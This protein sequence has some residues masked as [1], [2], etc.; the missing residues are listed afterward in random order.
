MSNGEPVIVFDKQAQII[1]NLAFTEAVKR[2]HG[3]VTPEHLL[4][5]LSFDKR[6]TKIMRACG[7]DIE[8]ARKEMDEFF[9]SDLVPSS[10][11]KK[12]KPT[13]AFERILQ[14]SVNQALS[15]GRDMATGSSLLAS[16]FE[17]TD[18]H[19]RYFLE[20]QNIT[21]FDVIQ[22]ISHGDFDD[23]DDLMDELEEMEGNA[24]QSNQ[25]QSDDGSKRTKVGKQSPLEKYTVNLCDRVRDGKV[26]PII[27]RETE[28][29]RA[30]QV[31]CRRRKNN[32]LFVGEPGVGKTALAEG[33]AQYI[34]EERVPKALLDA[35]IF[36]L[37][38]GSLMAGSKYR[39]DFE[40]R[41]KGILKALKKYAK[42]VLFIDEIHTIVGAG[43]V[44][45]GS[46]DLSNL[47]KPALANG[48]IR[49]MGATTYKEY[50]SQF[51]NDAAL[52]RRFLKIDVNEPSLEDAKNILEGIK[53]AFEEYHD[54]EYDQEALE[55]AVE[56]S[57]RYLSE[58]KLPDKAID[59]IDEAAARK[60]LYAD[61]EN[62]EETKVITVA[63][64]QSTIASMSKVNVED[65]QEE[66][67]AQLNHLAADLKALV[68]GQDHA[69]E[70][71]VNKIK[72]AR[73]GLNDDDKPIGSFLF[74]G[75]TGV[76]KTELAK[77]LA[78]QMKLEFN[79]F[80]MSEYMERHSVARLIGAP[81][82][83]VGYNEG[84]LLTDTI[85]QNPHSLVLLDEIEKAHPDVHNILLQIMDHG[86]V[87]D[88]VG[89]K[90]DCRNIILI[91]TTNTG[92][93]ELSSGKIGF[94]RDSDK[95]DLPAE[96]KEVFS[97]EFRNRL[98]AMIP[99]K[100]L[101]MPQV[102]LVAEKLLK[103]LSN[104]LLKKKITL[105]W[106]KPVIKILAKG[107]YSVEYGARPMR[108]LISEKI[109]VPL[110]QKMID[111]SF[112]DGDTVKLSI[113]KGEISFG[114]EKSE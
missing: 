65:L 27:G 60:A 86:F 48:D 47:L 85:H 76:G 77:R 79:R 81:P 90:T 82:G 51:Q 45:G 75:P 32:P 8:R 3:Y 10:D 25:S 41:L 71:V 94:S 44:S 2:K 54:V 102:E 58:L 113:T 114:A 6:V 40:Q 63:D 62:S 61:S 87:T 14:N 55:Q 20:K 13:M 33:M 39:G 100:P 78:E 9:D 22:Y 105:K 28:I 19:A 4:F 96:L 16:I 84:G 26:D 59:V 91:M 12:P 46:L 88:T 80:D 31:L 73:C 36:S 17:E 56:L 103:E 110:S 72:L 64:I 18:S 95:G 49:V 106:N 5:A 104:R 7:L 35:E 23:E 107:G 98:D 92:A 42:P 21:R 74:S 67:V 97:P 89:R 30:T 111:G 34:V 99:F 43:S 66:E 57:N 15:S 1:L 69:V 52:N 83:Y 50:R 70:Q 53:D 93:R 108:R 109:S 11:Q 29:K 37:D 68:Y 112:S 101:Q 38:I 24:H